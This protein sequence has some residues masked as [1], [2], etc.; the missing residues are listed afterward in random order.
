MKIIVCLDDNGGMLFCGRR[1]SSDRIAYKRILETVG[2]SVLLMNSYSAKQ[3]ENEKIM[4]DEN[5][6]DKAGAEDFCFVEN[7]DISSYADKIGHIIIY[8]WNRIYP[9]DIKFPFNLFEDRWQLVSKKDFA[10]NSHE[11]ITEEIYKL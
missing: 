5:F 3:F 8:R 11:K 9:S 1:Q 6:L 7:M 4:V 2:E 10:G